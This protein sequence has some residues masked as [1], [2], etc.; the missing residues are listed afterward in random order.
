MTAVDR[1]LRGPHRYPD[2]MEL[3]VPVT[4][5]SGCP[6]LFC[7]ASTCSSSCSDH[8]LKVHLTPYSADMDG[9][10]EFD[11]ADHDEMACLNRF[12]RPTC[13]LLHISSKSARCDDC[14]SVY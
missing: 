9:D 11:D 12:Q 13:K 1:D 6:T 5:T 7:R 8:V 14:R 10:D 4:I 2:V 3:T